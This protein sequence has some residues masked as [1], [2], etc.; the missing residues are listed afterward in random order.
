MTLVK[1]TYSFY[2]S[3]KFK[4]PHMHL[5]CDSVFIYIMWMN[6]IA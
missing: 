1:L 2:G 5:I 6:L 3:G 4:V